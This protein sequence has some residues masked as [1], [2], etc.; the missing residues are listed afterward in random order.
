MAR[1]TVFGMMAGLCFAAVSTV[2]ASAETLA[3]ALSSA[4]VTSGLL[5]QNRAVL[6]AADEDVA[7]AVA[8][9]RP[10]LSWSGNVT[11]SYGSQRSLESQT[12]YVGLVPVTTTDWVW[13][14]STSTTATASLLASLTV[15]AGGSRVM[16]FHAAREAVLATRA[17]LVSVEQQVLYNGVSAFMEMRRATETVALRRNNVRVINEELR[18]ARDRFEVGEV[19]RTD[20]AAA[21]ARLAAARSALAAAEGELMVNR[22]TYKAVIGH[23]PNGLVTPRSLPRLPGGVETAKAQAL[24]DHPNMIQLKHVVAANELGIDIAKARME[25]T[26]TVQGSWGVTESFDSK[27]ASRGGSVAIGVTGP[28]YQGGA[29]ASGVRQAMADRDAARAQLYTEGQTVEQNVGSA[30]AQLGI[31]QASL[32][33]SQEQV[34]AAQVAF[35]GIREEATLG[36]RTTLDVLDAEQELLDARAALISSQVDET[37]AAY[38]VLA[39][40]GQLTA[41]A[42]ALEVPRYDPAEY[43]NL[44]K[45]APVKSQQG[46]DLERVLRALGKN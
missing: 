14:G 16:G 31:Y 28:I 29:L 40:V 18:A 19:T 32:R 26:V 37:L 2:P 38:A 17:A 21:E 10:V 3:S 12:S 39:S 25:P 6:R 35:N 20:V 43:Y 30:Y 11:R 24:R 13:R 34:R 46:E 23:Y 4:Y 5:D 27:S 7:Q 8:S 9:L 44:V 45:T 36:A 33:S 22:E 42:L 41:Q 15:Y 1:R